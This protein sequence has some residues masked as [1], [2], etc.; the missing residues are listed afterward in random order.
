MEIF[1]SYVL[2]SLDC[3]EH[4]LPAL[5]KCLCARNVFLAGTIAAGRGIQFE[6]KLD[7][8]W[9]RSWKETDF[10][11]DPGAETRSRGGGKRRMGQGQGRQRM[12]TA[13]VNTALKMVD[14]VS[15][16][17]RALLYDVRQIT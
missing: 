6:Q 4:P 14:S 11:K 5:G 15:A 3:T 2:H 17:T 8:D 12:R 7:L 9:M 16:S 13:A 1:G 10:D